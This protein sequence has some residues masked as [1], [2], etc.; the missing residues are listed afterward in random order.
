MAMSSQPQSSQ[1]G[2][3]TSDDLQC[4]VAVKTDQPMSSEKLNTLFAALGPWLE[5]L[6]LKLADNG[7][8]LSLTNLPTL[9]ILELGM[10][11]KSPLNL[12]SDFSLQSL[13]SLTI[14]AGNGG[15][16]LGLKSCEAMHTRTRTKCVCSITR[17]T[18]VRFVCDL[19][20]KR[21]CVLPC[22]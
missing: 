21:V 13:Q 11:S 19:H 12:S 18:R 3:L 17:A 7:S 2:E 1:S 15:N 5:E 10:C 6:Y 4:R 16:A 8:S 9:H 14:N 22:V 20:A